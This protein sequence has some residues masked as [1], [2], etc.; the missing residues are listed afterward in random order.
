[1]ATSSTVTVPCN[2][3]LLLSLRV[4]P[5]LCRACSH[6]ALVTFRGFSL[7]T[8]KQVPITVPSNYPLVSHAWDGGGTERRPSVAFLGWP[9]GTPSL[10]YSVLRSAHLIITVVGQ[11]CIPE[12][13]NG[14][15]SPAGS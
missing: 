13:A 2:L 14:L 4:L 9:F 6:R 7:D 11:I 3:S 10:V 15:T 8:N 1:M 12:V 5:V